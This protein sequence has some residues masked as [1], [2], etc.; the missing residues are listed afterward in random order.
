MRVLETYAETISDGIGLRYAIYFAGCRHR[1]HGCHNPESWRDDRGR[2]LD[3][4]Y[5]IEIVDEIQ[6][7]PLLDGITLSGGDPFYDSQALLDFLEILKN[8]TKLNIWCY[9][10]YTY[11][12][13]QAD[14]TMRACLALID[15][16]VD[17]RYEQ[18]LADPTLYF[19]GSK[20]QRLLLLQAGKIMKELQ[21]EQHERKKYR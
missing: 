15:V 21:F 11:E 13:L 12:Q 17:G 14:D 5:Q 19:R 9:T 1:C 18:S 7:N 8:Q 6:D 16:L 10:G 3:E 2:V 20:N 4:A